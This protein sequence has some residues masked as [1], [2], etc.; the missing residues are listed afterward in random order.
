MLSNSTFTGSI[1]IN[2]SF[3]TPTITFGRGDGYEA[4]R[5]LVIDTVVRSR[6]HWCS[7]DIVEA[8]LSN[9]LLNI[10]FQVDSFH[11]SV[12]SYPPNAKYGVQEG[13]QMV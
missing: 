2:L 5:L 12:H 1:C 6:S 13:V 8:N 7:S 9:S 10:P 3:A 4:I 11:R